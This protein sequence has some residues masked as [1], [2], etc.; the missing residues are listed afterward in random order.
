MEENMLIKIC[1]I[2]SPKTAIACLEAGADM[3]GLVYYPPSPRHVDETKISEILAAV[4]PF[5][6]GGSRAILVVVDQL[7]GEIVSNSVDG[8]QLYRDIQADEYE[9]Y[10]FPDLT[11]RVVRDVATLSGL[12]KSS[13]EREHGRR[14]LLEL[15]Q[16]ILPGGNGAAWDWSK[17]RPFCE[18]YP[19]FLA[20][21]ITPENVIDAIRQADPYGIDVSSGVESAPGIKDMNKVRRLID[22]VREFQP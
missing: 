12:L 7:P 19:A 8:M 3:I 1:G 5:R 15:S 21:G 14:F 2:T 6:Q 20:G 11:I 22:T 10:R 4:T 16:G 13:A 9:R 18:R 17:A